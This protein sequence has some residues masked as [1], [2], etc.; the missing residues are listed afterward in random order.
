MM[1]LSAGPPTE[2]VALPLNAKIKAGSSGDRKS[3]VSNAVQS[4]V[5]AMWEKVTEDEALPGH[6]SIASLNCTTR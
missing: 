1:V 6:N 5:T 3:N 2:L 4:N